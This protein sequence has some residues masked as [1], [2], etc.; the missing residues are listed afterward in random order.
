MSAYHFDPFHIG[1]PV[2]SRS[3]PALL[4]LRPLNLVKDHIFPVFNCYPSLPFGQNAVPD[5]LFPHGPPVLL[6]LDRILVS[7]ICAEQR[8]R[9]R[10]M[11]Q[12]KG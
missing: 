10:L 2:V 1:M 6:A 5:G 4:W 12:R 11:Q 9:L 7:S 8:V 3:T